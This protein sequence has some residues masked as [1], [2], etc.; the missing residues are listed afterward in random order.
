MMK[1]EKLG[2]IGVGQMGKPM[3]I[4]LINAGYEVH[5]FDI[6]P[7][8]MQEIQRHGV[9]TR[10]SSRD[11]ALAA[12]D[13]IVIMVRNGKQEE[14]VILGDEGLI[15]SG[16][17]DLNLIVTST[18]ELK[19]VRRLGETT[20]NM[21][22]RMLNAPVSGG[23]AGAQ[24]GTLTL[25]VSGDEDLYVKSKPI[26]E[27]MGQKIFYFG[28]R[29]ETSQGAK[30]AN[31]LMLGIHIV[32]CIEGFRFARSIG[33]SEDTFKELVSHCT[34]DSWVARNWE[35]TRALWEDVKKWE[36]RSVLDNQ[37]KDMHAVLDEGRVPLPLTGL[38]T[39]FFLAKRIESLTAD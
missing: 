17:R 2:F 36:S 33:V 30:L 13:T 24:K 8:A 34:G 3:A 11:V 14:D 23:V 7:M 4:N 31:N 37:Y 25:M 27:A 16:R 26:L 5:A 32:G 18:I 6:N 21:G 39:E 20:A 15:S 22:C 1:N 29:Q 19:Y 35:W 9:T 12:D 28:T 38:V 10:S